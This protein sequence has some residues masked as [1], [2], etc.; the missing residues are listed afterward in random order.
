MIFHR[1]AMARYSTLLSIA[2][3]LAPLACRVKPKA[4]PQEKYQNLPSKDVPAVFNDS[5]FQRAD[6]QNNEGYPV[7]GYGLVVNLRGTGSGPYPTAIKDFMVKAMV[8]AGIGSAL[9]PGYEN[10]SPEQ[11]LNDKRIAIVQVDAFIP[12]GAR[13]RQTFDV[14]VSAIAQSYTTSLAGGEM[15]RTDLQE[16]QSTPGVNVLA[17]SQGTIFV[18]P[19]HVMESASGDISKLGPTARASLRSGVIM[20][21]G[22]STFDRPLILRLITPQ[23]SMARAIEARINDVFQDGKTASAIDE[24]LVYFYVPER[25]N[26]DWEHFSGIVTHLYFNGSVDFTVTKSKQLAAEAI[27][28][29]APLMDISYAWEGLGKN[30]LP[31]IVPLMTHASPDVAYAAARAAAFLEDSSALT[32]L[33]GMAQNN[34]HPFQIEAVQTLGKLKSSPLVNGMLRRLLDSDLNTVRIEAYSILAKNGDGSIY[35]KVIKSNSNGTLKEKYV[36]DI[37]PSKA[38]PVV[39]ASRTGTP[40]LAIIGD[41]AKLKV[42]IVWTTMN[43]TLMVASN[44]SGTGLTLFYRGTGARP[45]KVLSH[46]DLA[47]VVARLGGEGPLTEQ[48]LDFNYT[49]VVG[50]VQNLTDDKQVSALRGTTR[51]DASF[52]LQELSD[53]QTDILDT[54]IDERITRPQ[55]DAK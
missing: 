47:E 39:Y 1:P 29:D 12:P 43:E 48:R 11:M 17:R 50:I 8:K 44:E 46:M 24:A 30:A 16:R 36:L 2:L 52:V 51:V 20:D 38:A 40:R 33:M 15:Y 4:P 28:P 26:G 34:S 10:L 14:Y 54:P 41:G 22:V 49:D 37:V 25:F 7:T 35:S 55:A 27:K 13:D 21:G 5:I 23:R 18:N 19:T 3:L 32:A 6:L 45:I 31:H 9:Q 42:P 53:D